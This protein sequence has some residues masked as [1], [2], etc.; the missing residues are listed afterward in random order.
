MDSHLSRLISIFIF[1]IFLAVAPVSAGT[2]AQE[3]EVLALTGVTIIDGKGGAP[4][5]HMTLLISGGRIRDIFSD[6]KK[7]LPVKT[8]LM[9]LSGHCLIPGLID[10]HYHLLLNRGQAEEEGRMRFA[11]LGGVTTVRDMAGDAIKLAE[12]ARSANDPAV[13]FPRVYFSALF[14][15]PTWFSDDRVG[16]MM[17][18]LAPGQA[19]WARAVTP[20]TD[21]VKAIG[22]AK[23]T[24]ATGIK[25]YA[26]LTPEQVRRLSREAHRQGLKVWSH[27]TVFPSK[28]SDVIAAR[29]DVVSHIIDFV[30][31]TVDI[32]SK[33]FKDARYRDIDWP[34]NQPDV[35]AITDLLR[36]MRRQ[37]TILDATLLPTHSRI[38]ERELAKPEAERAIRDPLALDKWLF[39][40]TRLAHRMGVTLVAGT[41][42][43]EAPRRQELP[44]IHT[45]MELL[46][47]KCGLT[48][49]EA[50]RAATL[51][52]ALVLGIE[53]SYGTIAKGKVADLVVLSADPSADILNT[54]KI[55][56]IIKGGKVHKREKVSM[57]A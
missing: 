44:N 11:F 52:G 1:L 7:K 4:K 17:H 13:Q 53:A 23:A 21:I 45:E 15:G 37:G 31:E 12:V 50:I 33:Q 36:R 46:V 8:R 29:A 25:L 43:Q 42:I 35:P 2:S 26:D 18:G 28:P 30:W 9:D 41:D 34:N 14:A 38:V 54:R 19:A 39:G 47:S 22:E 57:P 55:V 6:G 24:G 48:P 27:L 32:H 20:E 3:S 49:L 10:S 40:V 51:N 16:L 56:F 5:P